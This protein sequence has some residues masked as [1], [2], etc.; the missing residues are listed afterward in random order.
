MG[1]AGSTD[2][3]NTVDIVDL[4]HDVSD[5]GTLAGFASVRADEA[6]AVAAAS[7]AAIGL[8]PDQLTSTGSGAAGAAGAGGAAGTAAPSEPLVLG[9]RVS[10]YSLEDR[11]LGEGGFGKVRLA[12]HKT[13][14]HQVAVKIIK[15]SKLKERAGVLLER[16]VKNHERLRHDNIVRL[17]TSIRTP[18][19]YY[20]V[21]QVCSRGDLLQYIHDVGTVPDAEARRYF[22]QLLRG[23][24]FC[25]SLGVHH[26]DLKLENLLLAVEPPPESA[27]DA[28]KGG[29]SLV[30][31]ISDFGLSDLR[32]FSLSGTY[33]G[34]PLYAA[35]E[36]MDADSRAAS[37][38]GY[39][40]SQS[41]MW[42]CGVVLYALLTSS[43]PFDADDMHELIRLIIRA[44]PRRALPRSRGTDAADLVSQLIRR[45]PSSRLAAADCLK[46]PWVAAD[47][48]PRDK[49]DALPPK[50]STMPT[51]PSS[52]PTA[53]NTADEAADERADEHADG[54]GRRGVSETSQ[55]YRNLIQAEAA[56]RKAEAAAQ[57]AAARGGG[58]ASL[59][60]VNATPEVSALTL[61]ASRTSEAA[62][63]PAGEQPEDITDGSAASGAPRA[64]GTHLTK[65]DREAIRAM[66]QQAGA[67]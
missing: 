60:G 67:S 20:L 46:H 28:G 22:T 40:A 30:L 43:L 57:E 25:H 61:S 12:T 3:G 52:D 23:I 31:K 54:Q 56:R 19:K 17:Y 62:P 1:A 53:T 41:D 65:E 49:A 21:M 27:P 33:C 5:D 51:L 32:P 26:R 66:K 6:A 7:A 24:H 63:A 29:T 34:S 4:P 14:G 42:S 37:P 59:D 15:R 11:V 39:D 58:S 16:E 44:I 2:G 35:P 18:S 10:D 64:P 13:T 36:L 45:D 47:E 9:A 48:P 55:F 50:A 8:T 38:E